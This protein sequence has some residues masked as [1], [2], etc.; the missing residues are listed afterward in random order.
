M[1]YHDSSQ[2]SFVDCRE[3]LSRKE[4]S[5]ENV[6]V[7]PMALIETEFLRIQFQQGLPHEVGINGVR[8]EDVLDVLIAKLNHYQE[9]PLACREN[10]EAL[11]GLVSARDAMVRRR[12]RRMM[13]GVFNTMNPHAERTEDLDQDFSATGA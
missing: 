13:Q 7:K 5:M 11:S 3:N 6:E 4:T 2:A 12:Q 8:I 9:G 1:R 10:E